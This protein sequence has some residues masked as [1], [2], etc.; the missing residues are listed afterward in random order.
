MSALGLFPGL[1]VR[2]EPSLERHRLLTVDARWC[3]TAHLG[4]VWHDRA[5]SL[6]GRARDRLP[7]H[8]DGRV[9]GSLRDVFRL[10]L[11]GLK[12]LPL[13]LSNKTHQRES[14]KT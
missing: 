10:L 5:L 11:A 14:K 12:L 4:S 7:E 13:L 1:V 6:E 3:Y 9:A 2:Y 8:G